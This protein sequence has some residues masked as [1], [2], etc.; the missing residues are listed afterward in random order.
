MKA[1]DGCLYPVAVMIAQTRSNMQVTNGLMQNVARAI[2]HHHN[3]IH[4]KT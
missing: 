4:P 2:I 1:P 3:E